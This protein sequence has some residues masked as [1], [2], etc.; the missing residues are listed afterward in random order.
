MHPW[1]Y[2]GGAFL[3]ITSMNDPSKLSPNKQFVTVQV[4]ELKAIKYQLFN[5]TQ[6]IDAMISLLERSE[7]DALMLMNTICEILDIDPNEITDQN[8]K[9]TNTRIII[10]FALRQ[11]GVSTTQI[12]KL[13]NRDHST[14]IYYL[15]KY[16]EKQKKSPTFEEMI[17]KVRHLYE[18]KKQ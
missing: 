2:A 5:A 9:T 12:G 4:S 16:Y 1:Q 14:V 13:L 8:R 15:A 10:A 3:Q 7:F 6:K 18:P 11:K 17:K